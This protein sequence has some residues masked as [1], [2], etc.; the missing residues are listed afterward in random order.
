MGLCCLDYDRPAIW[1]KIPAFE[2]NP[3]VR[4][5]ALKI[6]GWLTFINDD[7]VGATVAT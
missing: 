7:I 6:S 1:T 4:P 3:T 5:I 2:T